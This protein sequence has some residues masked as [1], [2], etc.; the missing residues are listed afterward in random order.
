MTFTVD[1]KYSHLN[2]D[3]LMQQ[4][5]IHLLKKQKHF[6]NCFDRF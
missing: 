3:R 5:Q 6:V 2:S 4:I 1:R